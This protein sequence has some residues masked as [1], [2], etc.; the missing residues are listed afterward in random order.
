MATQFVECSICCALTVPESADHHR[1]WHKT[2]T[3][4]PH[5]ETE[6][7]P[8]YL[9][10]HHIDLIDE[11]GRCVGSVPITNTNTIYSGDTISIPPFKVNIPEDREIS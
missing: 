6:E 8:R 9:N 1:E 4:L 7:T 2:M 10:L 11:D 5:T 3:N